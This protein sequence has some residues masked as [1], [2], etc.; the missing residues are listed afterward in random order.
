[1]ELVVFGARRTS[2][3]LFPRIFISILLPSSYVPLF[4]LARYDFVFVGAVL[5]QVALVA[6]KVETRD[7]A[8]TLFAFHLCSASCWRSSRPTPPWGRSYPQEGFLEA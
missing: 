2:A 8:L 1:V 6:L 5:A 4:G 3:C 7:E